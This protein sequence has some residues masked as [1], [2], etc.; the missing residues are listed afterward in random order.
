[1]E[2]ID[3]ALVEEELEWFDIPG[4]SGAKL[5]GPPDLTGRQ[6]K[7]LVAIVEALSEDSG[8]VGAV[9][10]VFN[11]YLELPET[12]WNLAQKNGDGTLHEIP[13]TPDSVK[14]ELRRADYGALTVE[15]TKMLF[16]FW[17]GMG[18]GAAPDEEDEEDVTEGLEME[19]G[20]Q[21]EAVTAE[22]KAAD[23]APPEKVPDPNPGAPRGRKSRA[24]QRQ[25]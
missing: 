11:Y 14:D 10:A 20:S 24:A 16:P 17:F 8:D 3:Y 12:R 1:M 18:Q 4:K 7:Q 9:E 23:A 2:L 5:G 13:L 19:P 6:T 15:V 22:E 21:A 25:N